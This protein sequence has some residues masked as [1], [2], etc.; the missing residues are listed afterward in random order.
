MSNLIYKFLDKCAY[1]GCSIIKEI[2][3]DKYT[4]SFRLKSRPILYSKDM[5][6]VIG[7]WALEKE[8]ADEN[9]YCSG[10]FA[11]YKIGRDKIKELIRD[12]PDKFDDIKYMIEEQLLTDL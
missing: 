8:I 10:E 2:E 9:V 7:W 6:E 1:S 5:Q 11:K 4:I 3:V 12:Y